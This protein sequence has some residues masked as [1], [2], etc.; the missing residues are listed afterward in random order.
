MICI[1]IKDYI[2]VKAG[3]ISI[4]IG[5]SSAIIGGHFNS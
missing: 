4:V 2:L 3:V 1:E 5:I